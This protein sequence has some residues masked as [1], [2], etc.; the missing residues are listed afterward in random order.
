M[1]FNFNLLT[2][3][4]S[5][6]QHNWICRFGID[7]FKLFKQ[8]PIGIA[9]IMSSTKLNLWIWYLAIQA[10]QIAIYW[11]CWS[12]VFN[13]IELKIEFVYLVFINISYL[14]SIYWHWWNH[15]LTKTEFVDLVLT[16]LSYLNSN[17]L[18]LLKSC[19]QQNWICGF[20]I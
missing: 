6:P 18:A 9:E 14:S 20:G 12:H 15:A 2:L 10:I 19:H 7:Q 5:C 17:L 13:K 16:N 11:H 3:L 1:F 8:Q 4:K